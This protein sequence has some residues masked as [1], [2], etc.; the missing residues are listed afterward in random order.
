MWNGS[1]PAPRHTFERL[2][3][4]DWRPPYAGAEKRGRA[5]PL[6]RTR[7]R[8]RAR[9]ARRP[10]ESQVRTGWREDLDRRVFDSSLF[11]LRFPHRTPLLLQRAASRAA[12][13]RSLVL[14]QWR[15]SYA[16][17]GLPRGDAA[18]L[19]PC[20][21]AASRPLVLPPKM[22]VWVANYFLSSRP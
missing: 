17:G 5:L 16:I 1:A 8:W 11:A 20:R 3:L 2:L 22:S 10:F 9:S 14:P 13:R 18:A 12:M 6:H 4:L 21:D 15:R 19:A 7:Q